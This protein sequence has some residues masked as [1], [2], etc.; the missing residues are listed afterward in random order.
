MAS[1]GE[2]GNM[3]ALA[4]EAIA[5]NITLSGGARLYSL[6]GSFELL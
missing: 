4:G 5:F 6:R 3:S 2:A 1:W